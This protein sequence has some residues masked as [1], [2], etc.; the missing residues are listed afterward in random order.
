MTIGAGRTKGEVGGT[1]RPRL[2]SLLGTAALILGLLSVAGL[3]QSTGSVDIS[4]ESLYVSW[5]EQSGSFE[6]TLG[7]DQAL[8]GDTIRVS[9]KVKNLGTTAAGEFNVE[10]FFTET[11][12]GEH[13]KI[14]TQTVAGLAPGEESR[15]VVTVDSSDWTPGIYSFYAVADP[16]DELGDADRCNN[17]SPRLACDGTAAERT[18][19]YTLTLLREGRHISELTLQEPFS[20]CRMAK[21]QTSI[22]VLLDNVGTETL[23]ASDLE[24]WGYYRL[25]LE[26]PADEFV[27]LTTDADGNPTQLNKIVSLGDPGDPGFILITLNYD[28]FNRLLAPTA[29]EIASGDV[30]GKADPVQLRITVKPTGSSEGVTQQDVY[31]PDAFAL[32]QFYSTVDLW[33][34]PQRSGCCSTSCGEAPTSVLKPSI[35]GGLVFF[36]V[37]DSG[38]ERLHVLKVRTGEEKAVWTLPSGEF[39]AA[40]LVSYD[41]ATQVYRVYV[42]SSDGTLYALDGYDKDE[43]GF[44]T[45]VWQSSSG[46]ASPQAAEGATTFLRFSSD[47]AEIV[48]GSTH[49][50]YTLDPSNG[51][52]LVSAT[53]HGAAT[54]RPAY[55]DENS[56]LWYAA[57]EIV[58]GVHAN[59]TEC[60]FDVADRISTQVELT[61]TSKAVLFGTETGYLY[62]LDAEAAVG[63]CNT[64][65]E[66]QPLRTI[67]G[68]DLVKDK[69][70]AVIYLTSDIGQIARVEYDEGRGFRNIETSERKYEPTEILTAPAILPNRTADDASILFVTGTIR[71]GRITR[72]ILQGWAKNLSKYESVDVWGTSTSFLFKPKEAGI[73]PESLLAPVVDPETYTLLVVSSDGYLYAFDLSQFE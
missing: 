32:S 26:P 65:A 12:S 36:A 42:A 11:I 50:A 37:S 40:P 30:L 60:S 1:N 68:M 4:V 48:V 46:I 21:L 57:D 24:V 27:P 22:T 38:G 47:E 61:A 64:K 14:G 5:I 19:R 20:T 34:Y 7:L 41:S 59:G 67:V 33:T 63:N 31:L 43:G 23:S 66:E 51:Q 52:T 54:T 2:R 45:Q 56:V 71:E 62:A 73:I 35:S 72:P 53:S 17:G 70:D 49:G 39:A 29:S 8:V 28:V 44:F 69:D 9:A 6:R 18:D 55:D 10:F 16:L 58:Y 3:G 13:G 15:P 25:A